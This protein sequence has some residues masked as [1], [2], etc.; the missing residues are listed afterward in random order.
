MLK[1]LKKI[2]PYISTLL[3]VYLIGNI[4]VSQN[5]STSYFKLSEF[6][7]PKNNLH[8]E[9]FDFLISIRKLSEYNVFSTRF[10]A[11]F[12]DSLEADIR[13]EDEKRLAYFKNLEYIIEKNPKSRDALLKL[14]LYYIQENQPDKAVYYLNKAKEID[15]SLEKL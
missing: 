2:H 3:I 1:I 8:K 14:Y 6:N 11:I 4:V 7:L 15:P 12:G 9:A 10:K 13:K 5:I